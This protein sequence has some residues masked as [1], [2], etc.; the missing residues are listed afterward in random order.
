MSKALIKIVFGSK[1]IVKKVDLTTK[2]NDF[3]AILKENMP[4]SSHFIL[5]DAFIEKDDEAE[6]TIKD[7][8]K[9]N[10]VFCSSNTSS[11]DIYL[12]NEIIC[13][14]E[15]NPDEKFENLYKEIKAKI[16]K[17]SKIKFEDTELTIEDAKNEE[18][19]VKELSAQNSIYFINDETKDNSKN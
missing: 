13:K 12:N 5:D 16:P 1:K 9:N 10:E 15:I 7:I 2:L 11:I 19:T 14:H 17:D 3:R 8:I 18:M 4:E 6:L